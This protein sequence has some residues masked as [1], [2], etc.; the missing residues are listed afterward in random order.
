MGRGYH[1]YL[2]DHVGFFLLLR[3]TC[4]P[5]LGLCGLLQV[6]CGPHL[7]LFGLLRVMCGAYPGLCGLLRVMCGPYF[8][9]FRLLQVMCGPHLGLFGLLQVIYLY[10]LVCVGYCRLFVSIPW[11]VWATAGYVSPH[12]GLCG[13]LRV[14]CGPY[15]GLCGPD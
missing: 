1:L 15:L 10:T 3:V 9:L 8:A 14:R 4:G 6:M 11:S 12:P 2:P 13:L 7:G 5:L